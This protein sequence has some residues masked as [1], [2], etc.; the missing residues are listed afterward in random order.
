MTQLVL[1]KASL[2]EYKPYTS[3]YAIDITAL[4]LICEQVGITTGAG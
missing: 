1:R 3:G 4:Q 2:E